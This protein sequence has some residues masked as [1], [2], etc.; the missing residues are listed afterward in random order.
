MI[1][2]KKGDKI[3]LLSTAYAMVVETLNWLITT[4]EIE[5]ITVHVKFPLVDE[6]QLL[7]DVTVALQSHPDVKI[8]IF[9]HISSIVRIYSY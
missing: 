3:L 8:A 9:S 7:E 5:V 2:L 1:R 4:S 6:V